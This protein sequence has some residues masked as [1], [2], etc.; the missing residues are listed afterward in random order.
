M[1][2]THTCGQLRKKDIGKTVE[3]SGWVQ[4]YRD[5]GGVIFIDLRDRY[6]LTQIVFDPSYNK[7]SHKTANLVRR[8]YVIRIKGKVR[9]RGDGLVNPKLKTG[10]IEILADEIEILTKSLTPPFEIEDKIDVKE[11]LKLKYRYLD[12]RRPVMKNNIITRHNTIQIVRQY[13]NENDFLEIETP[14][15]AKS[16][17]EGARD[18][19]VPS[20]VNIGKF[21][22][23]PQSPQLYKQILMM[24]GMDRYYQIAR[25]LRDED[26]R[27]DRQ[28]E[29]TQIDIEMS[30]ID[31][32][33]IQRL[34]EGLLKRIWKKILKLDIKTPFPIMTYQ[35]AMEHYGTDRPDTRFG[36]ELINVVDEIKGSGFKV[37]E[38]IIRA[39]G[40]IKCINVKNSG[41]S[42]KDIDSFIEFVK[43]YDAKGLAWMRMSDKLS[44]SITKYFSDKMLQKIQKKTKAKKGDLLLFVADK[45]HKI[46]NDALGALRL[47][48]GKDLGLIDEDKHNFLWVIDFPM[49]EFDEE[50]QRHV[51]VHHPFTSPK[52]EDM[53]Y[54]ESHPEKVRSRAYD[55]V[56]NGW[57]LG[58][59]S[60]RIHDPQVQRRVFKVLGLSK[61]QVEERF[62]FL[63]EAFKYGAPPHG[64]IAFG[65]DRLMALITKS[66]SLREV[67][68]FPKNKNAEELMVGSPSQVSDEQLKEL[69]IRLDFVKKRY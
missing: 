54:L 19:L 17:P 53:K 56:L 44:S 40:C 65:F 24:S 22:A 18:Y 31:E 39:G 42:R 9:Y 38:D 5:H 33:D 34:V 2:R 50:E 46:V 63:L 30:F 3:L 4:S 21:Y 13:L 62:G 7:Q 26:L 55:I 15:L 1:L 64:G 27:A 25:C 60:I 29:F 57:E 32:S 28:P 6:G 41:F 37:F 16:T 48:I 68:A 23:L 45:K 8:E 36:F 59:G 67:I 11:D 58:G 52:L 14:M 61:K 66:P 51:A 47:K 49:L 20:R 10:E 43:I 35:E 69:H 12:L